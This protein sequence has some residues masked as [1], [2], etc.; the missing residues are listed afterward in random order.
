LSGK[1]FAENVATAK[2]VEFPSNSDEQAQRRKDAGYASISVAARQQAKAEGF[3][4]EVPQSELGAEQQL[5]LPGGEWTRSQRMGFYGQIRNVMSREHSRVFHD[6]TTVEEAFETIDREGNKPLERI[7]AH[8][9]MS[10]T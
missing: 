5:L 4:D 8:R 10:P 1:A 2:F 3:Y 7:L 9:G 6:V